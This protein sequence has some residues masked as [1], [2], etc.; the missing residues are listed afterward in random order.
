MPIEEAGYSITINKFWVTALR[1][2][3]IAEQPWRQASATVKGKIAERLT[4]ATFS[5]QAEAQA[6][7]DKLK[8]LGVK[9]V[10]KNF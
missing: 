8:E 1:D 10:A 4:K 5:T 7:H 3:I 2:P 6:L 9:W